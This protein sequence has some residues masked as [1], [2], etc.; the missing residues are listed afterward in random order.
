MDTFDQ[1]AEDAL[2]DPRMTYA[3]AEKVKK[4]PEWA[5]RQEQ[6]KATQ[7][8][9]QQREEAVST[10]A[11]ISGRLDEVRDRYRAIS[12]AVEDGSMSAL[13]A[14]NE[15]NNLRMTVGSEERRF[16]MVCSSLD[17]ADTVADDPVGYFDRMYAK[18]PSLARNRPT[19]S[20]YLD[21]QAP[22]TPGRIGGLPAFRTS[23]N[24]PT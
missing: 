23:E 19:L 24:P 7:H 13:D 11:E 8:A 18:Y 10:A 12:D 1:I 6:A 9:V 14:V 17:R 2:A 22:V 16:D 21:A 5:R 3:L 4:F 20:D 15:M